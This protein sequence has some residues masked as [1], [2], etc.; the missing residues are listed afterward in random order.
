MYIRDNIKVKT[1][2]SNRLPEL[3]LPLEVGLLN[4]DAT[5]QRKVR[6]QPECTGT[7]ITNPKHMAVVNGSEVHVDQPNP[8][9]RL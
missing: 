5:N 9:K 6:V 2:K 3:I 1:V 7:I 4:R 8:W